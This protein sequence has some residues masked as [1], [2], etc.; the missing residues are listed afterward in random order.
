MN[1]DKMSMCDINTVV[2]IFMDV[3]LTDPRVQI[4]GFVMVADMGNMKREKILK[5]SDSRNSKMSAKYFQV[6]GLTAAP[7]VT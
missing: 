2:Q 7:P 1:F 5:L 4:G 3:C 6:N